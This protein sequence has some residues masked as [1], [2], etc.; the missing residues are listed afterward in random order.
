MKRILYFLGKIEDRITGVLLV[1]LTTLLFVQI[2]NRYIFYRSDVWIEEICRMSFIWLVYLS[3]AI[4]TKEGR[5]IRVNLVDLFLP[6][7][8]LKVLTLIADFFW[9]CFNLIL[10]YLGVLLVKSTFEYKYLAP[11]TNVHMGIIY[12]VIPFAFALMTFRVVYYNIKERKESRT[13]SE[14]KPTIDI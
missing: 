7:S 11:V 5:H 9:L 4:A 6:P 12:S 13:T 14:N 3:V 2:L 10:V 1:L 8:V